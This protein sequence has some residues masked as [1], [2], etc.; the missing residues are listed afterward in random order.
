VGFNNLILEPGRKTR[1]DLT[2]GLEKGIFITEIL[3]GHTADPIS[4]D[5]S[6]GAA[7]RL[8]EN[9]VLTS[10]VKSIAI[11]GNILDVFGSMKE[12]ANDFRFF[13]TTGCASALVTEMSVSGP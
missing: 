12:I 3:G 2:K 11:A 6:F 8:I 7:G 5:F 4:G 1:A 13:G 10:P 9:G